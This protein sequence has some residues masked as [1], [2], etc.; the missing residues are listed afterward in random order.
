M[1]PKAKGRRAVGSSRLV[2]GLGR[3]ERERIRGN[4]ISLTIVTNGWNVS[5]C[6][7]VSP[8]RQVESPVPELV[9]VPWQG[10]RVGTT[11][12]W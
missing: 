10:P 12:L 6:G 11:Q 8:A 5:G 1:G 9:S 4:G 7:H 2:L 3:G